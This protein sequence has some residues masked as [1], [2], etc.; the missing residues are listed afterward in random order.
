VPHC[1]D[2]AD[3]E[4]DVLEWIDSMRVMLSDLSRCFEQT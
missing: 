3:S 4:S 1:C 2:M